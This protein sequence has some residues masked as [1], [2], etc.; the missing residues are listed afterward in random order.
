MSF[1]NLLNIDT[2]LNA[3][4]GY[5]GSKML[6]YGECRMGDSFW[7]KNGLTLQD[8]INFETY[9][10]ACDDMSDASVHIIM[11]YEES[12]L[13]KTRDKIINTI[14]EINNWYKIG[15]N[16]PVMFCPVCLNYHATICL[17]GIHQTNNTK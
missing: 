13:P 3:P 10:Y 7:I 9:Q 12:V 8:K 5:F 2:R 6:E 16:P 14:V 4:I 15:N 1:N 17:P 11:E